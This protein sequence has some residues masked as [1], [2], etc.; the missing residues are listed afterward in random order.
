MRAGA[1]QGVFGMGYSVAGFVAPFIVTATVLT[2][3]VAGLVHA[4]GIFVLAA[5]GM[6]AI[7]WTAKR[8]VPPVLAD[9]KPQD[10]NALTA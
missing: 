7:A 4:R 1:Y 8:V 2:M 5:A 6:T 10:D 9:D 3:G